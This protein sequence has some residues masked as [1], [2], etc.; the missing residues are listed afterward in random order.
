MGTTETRDL[1]IVIKN[2]SSRVGW[3]Q[4][5]LARH[6]YCALNDD[7][8]EIDMRRFEERLKKE[9]SRETT[10]PERLRCYL[11]VMRHLPDIHK[12]NL[13]IPLFHSTKLLNREL[14]NAF[15]QFSTEASRELS[16]GED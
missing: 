3:S 4:N 5:Q 15:I 12:A 8:N 16:K 6:L 9:L 1:Q 7:D 14:E 2:L 10:N 11:E 13:V